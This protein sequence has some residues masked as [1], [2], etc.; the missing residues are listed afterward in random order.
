[1]VDQGLGTRGRLATQCGR[2]KPCAYM[3][4]AKPFNKKELWPLDPTPSVAPYFFPLK[5]A[6]RGTKEG[7]RWEVASCRS[8]EG[9]ELQCAGRTKKRSQK[10]EGAS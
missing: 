10:G 8:M 4:T 7:E 3:T 9:T 6:E 2:G 5:I 1:M